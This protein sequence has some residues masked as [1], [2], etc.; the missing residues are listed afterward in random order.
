MNDKKDKSIKTAFN[1]IR[2]FLGLLLASQVIM[3]FLSGRQMFFETR[4]PSP[5]VAGINTVLLIATIIHLRK[6]KKEQ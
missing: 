1:D 6:F 5:I 2:L 3:L 4:D